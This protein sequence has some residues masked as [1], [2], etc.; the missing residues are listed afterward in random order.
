[1]VIPRKRLFIQSCLTGPTVSGLNCSMTIPLN[2]VKEI[3]VLFPRDANDLTVFINPEYHHLQLTLLNRNFPMNG[4]NT[5]STEFYRIELESCNL[6]IILPPT[7]SFE[8]SYKNKVC[9]DFPF[10]GRCIGDDTDFL[11]IYNL[12]RQSPNACF[13]DPANSNNESITLK[14]TPQKQEMGDVYYILNV[15]DDNADLIYNRATPI[16]VIISDTFWMLSS[17]SRAQYVNDMSWNQ[18]LARFYPNVL[19]RL[20]GQ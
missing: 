19:Q 8:N 20:T 10:S 15:E 18:C 2:N 17:T 16:L 13:S 11:L 6:D 14:G 1:L 4:A 9:S 12:E 7:E 5:T 3:I